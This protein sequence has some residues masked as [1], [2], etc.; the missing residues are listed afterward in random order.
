MTFTLHGFDGLAGDLR[1]L[2]K[3][4]RRAAKPAIAR[5]AK[6]LENRIRAAAPIDSGELR[7]SITSKVSRDGMSATITAKARH[8]LPVEFGTRFRPASPFFYTT[9]K[10]QEAAIYAAIDRAVADGLK[11]LK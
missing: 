1:R 3:D 7:R 5:S 10:S 8:A 6:K 4:I 2:E 11:A 9:A